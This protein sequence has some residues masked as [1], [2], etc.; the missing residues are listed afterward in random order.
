M[1]IRTL[2]IVDG[3][4]TGGSL[5]QARLGTKRNI[6][7]WRDALYSGPVPRDLTLRRLSRLRSRYWTRKS[8]T[9]FDGRDATLAH[10]ADYDEIVLWFGPTSICQLSLIQLLHWFDKHSRDNTRLRLVSA[11]G[12]WLKPEQVLKA[13]DSR[14]PITPSQ[15]RLGRRAW[16]AFCSPS[17][18]ALSQLLASDLRV[19]PEIRDTIAFL[20]REYPERHSGL[21]RLERKLLGTVNSLGIT[22]PAVTV[23]MTLHS[24]L[25]GD[26][27]LFDM[28]R[29]LIAAPHPLLRFAEPFQGTLTNYQFNGSEI[30]MT[31]TGL[32]V[33]AGSADHITLNGIDRW[34]GGVHLSGH[35]VPWRWDERTATIIS[36]R[37]LAAR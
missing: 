16:L 37:G 11:Y 12:G 20:L 27:L 6:L 19:L 31:D 22:T 32:A 4:S 23:G 17:P 8:D 14:Q 21:S 34:I 1:M 18:N 15:K 24:E 30:E 7:S 36:Q 13:Y 9:E 29:A 10:H 2:H 28:L 25:V 5:R 33:L 26:T 35:Q 3:E